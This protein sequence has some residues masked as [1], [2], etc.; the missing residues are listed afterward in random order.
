MQII[1]R[2]M[3]KEDIEDYVRWFTEETT[4]MKTDAPWEFAEAEP[5][6]AEA[7]RSSWT[8]YYEEIRDRPADA[9]RWKFEI[10]ADGRHVGWVSCYDDLEYVPNP[11]EIPAVGIDIPDVSVWGRGVATTAFR[12]Y[13]DYLKNRG[14][15]CAYTQTW[16]G[17]HAMLRVAEKLGF[18]E[19]FRKKNH[20]TVNGEQY[21]AVTL[22]I[23]L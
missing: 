5:T 8:E 14:Y 4:W 6:T 7:E 23:G 12:M 1:L 13:L 19:Y 18:T 20:R 21:D 22:K 3:T 16:S 9:P 15:T 17:N 11:E 2:D 10:E